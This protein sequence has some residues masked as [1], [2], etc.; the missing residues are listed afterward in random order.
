MSD[1]QEREQEWET[2]PPEEDPSAHDYDGETALSKT[3]NAQVPQATDQPMSLRPVSI[4]DV[5]EQVERVRSLMKDLMEEDEHF[6]D[7]T[8]S[9]KPSLFQP[10]AELLCSA[11]GMTPR[12]E[13]E[14]ISIT[15]NDVGWEDLPPGHREV[16]VTC[17]LYARGSGTFLGEGV[18]SC[19][20]LE[21]KYRWRTAE[22]VTDVKVP[23]AFWNTYDKEKGET[24]GDADFS[25]LRETLNAALKDD[26]IPE[27]AD[28]GVEFVD[29]T[30]FIKYE[31]GR[32]ENPDIAAQW[33]TVLKMGKK[34]SLV[35]AAKTVTG[36]S[37]MFT[38]D[39][40]DMPEFNPEAG[41]PPQRTGPQ[42][43]RVK[44]NRQPPKSDSQPPKTGG[45][46]KGSGTDG[47]SDEIAPKTWATIGQMK[48]RLA[49]AKAG[50]TDQ[51]LE[52]VLA[53]CLGFIEEWPEKEWNAAMKTIRPFVPE[54]CEVK[55]PDTAPSVEGQEDE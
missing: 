5:R 50:R 51:S 46:E 39:V 10:G 52:E 17:R 33:N 26:A 22:E 19:S 53:S 47:G 12:Y 20:T 54:D 48:S 1:E 49:D 13:V 44:T 6:G 15:S 11:F 45:E 16:R 55:V 38:Q 2:V 27:N 4:E 21:P 34:R 32:V 28:V 23:K 43:Q 40:E 31:A 41:P 37:D 36:A 24:M 18:G 42:G 14:I 30:P 8:G 29:N 9:G 3:P 7:V 25:M 35:D